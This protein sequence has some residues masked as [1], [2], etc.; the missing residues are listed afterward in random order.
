[1]NRN[2]NMLI[3]LIIYFIFEIWCHANNVLPDQKTSNL[4]WNI[5]I[6]KKKLTSIVAEMI[7]NNCNGCWHC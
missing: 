4:Y 7:E 5:Y 2:K 1:M 6:N 3:K